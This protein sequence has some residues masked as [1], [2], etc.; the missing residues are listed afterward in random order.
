MC[1]V[2]EL[3]SRSLLM[4]VSSFQFNCT[5]RR[6]QEAAETLPSILPGPAKPPPDN[7]TFSMDLYGRMPFS[8]PSRQ[9]F[10]T[11]SQRQQVYVEVT[12]P[13]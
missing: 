4:F 12:S 3:P 11:V 7:L 1:L 10:Y 5:Y 13:L 2:P 6:T 9:A 8:D